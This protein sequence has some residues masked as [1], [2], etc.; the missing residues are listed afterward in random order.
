MVPK[1]SEMA[2]RPALERV[3]WP[4]S[5]PKGPNANMAQ[6]TARWPHMAFQRARWAHGVSKGRMGTWHLKG[7]IDTWLLK[8]PHGHMTT[9]RARW[10]HGATNGQM[11]TWPLKWPNG[12]TASKG[13]DGDMAPQGPPLRA[14]VAIWAFLRTAWSSSPFKGNVAI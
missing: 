11:R 12:D 4:S 3:R 13:P 10:P 14:H 2:T 1:K 7:Q 9:H 5:P 8:G 6:Q